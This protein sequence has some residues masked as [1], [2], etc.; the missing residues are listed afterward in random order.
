MAKKILTDKE[1]KYIY[2][3]VPR[4]C[5]DIIVKTPRGIIL[6]LRNIEPY[7][8]FWHIPGGTVYYQETIESATRRIARKELGVEVDIG[9]LVGLIEYT[10]EQ[11]LRGWGR[12]ISLLFFCSVKSGK[13]KINKEAKDTRFFKRF[14]KLPKNI[15]AEQKRF[16]KKILK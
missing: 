15:V 11:K 14:E 2:S 10:S 1:Y 7:K 9:S 3:R 6:T 13:L 12:T 8:N 4:L 16:L 5:V